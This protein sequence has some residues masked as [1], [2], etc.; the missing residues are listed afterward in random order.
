M[1]QLEDMKAQFQ[2]ENTEMLLKLE[3]VEV[4][5]KDHDN[6]TVDLKNCDPLLEL[7]DIDRRSALDADRGDILQEPEQNCV[8][9]M[10][11]DNDKL[12]P[13]P[14]EDAAAGVP[15]INT[16]KLLWIEDA[17]MPQNRDNE[18]LLPIE[19]TDPLLQLE[20]MKQHE[21]QELQLFNPESH[22]IQT[23]PLHDRDEDA[24]EVTTLEYALPVAF[25]EYFAPP[26]HLLGPACSLNGFVCD[27]CSKVVCPHCAQGN[28]T[29]RYF[30]HLC[31]EGTVCPDC[32]IELEAARA[33]ETRRENEEL[34][35][36]NP[37]PLDSPDF[38]VRRGRAKILFSPTF[39]PHCPCCKK[40]R[41]DHDDLDH[42]E[43]R[44]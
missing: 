20:D 42:A 30:C 37:N 26:P 28:C 7:H 8:C 1:L 9:G 14:I 2:G 11:G 6:V 33:E 10:A 43:M 15:Q 44:E 40:G 35:T 5:R 17:G 22:A 16:A 29:P 3:D 34:E 25:P 19:A 24:F 36:Q 39:T 38:A 27:L 18:M 13:V 21:A 31:E 4:E 23:Y 32:A 41:D 12:L